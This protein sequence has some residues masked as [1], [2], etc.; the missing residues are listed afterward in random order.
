MRSPH[1]WLPAQGLCAAQIL[2]RPQVSRAARGRRLLRN[3]AR[4]DPQKTKH[5]P[6]AVW[7]ASPS[8]QHDS[9]DHLLRRRH[10]AVRSTMMMTNGPSACI[11]EAPDVP[12]S[13]AQAAGGRDQRH[14]PECRQRVLAL[15]DARHRF[16]ESAYSKISEK[17]PR[18][19]N[20]HLAQSLCGAQGLSESQI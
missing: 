20:R 4:D 9:D 19:N 16:V 17:R 6:L 1:P 8:R 10:A 15:F 13:Q 18:P 14:L 2:S 7:P 11:G 12:L 3:D 5:S